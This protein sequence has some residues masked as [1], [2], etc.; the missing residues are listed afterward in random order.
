M[1]K[2]VSVIK[3]ERDD[4]VPIAKEG[5]LYTKLFPHIKPLD[6]ILFKGQDLVSDTIR[7][8]EYVDLKNNW[9]DDYTH[10]GII[11][12]RELLDDERL[13]PSKL[14]VWESTISGKLGGGVYNIQGESHLGVQVRDF[15]EV[16]KAYDEPN[17]TQIAWC[18]LNNNP[19][20]DPEKS[21]EIKTKFRE[22]FDKYNGIRYDLNFFSLF[23]SF[24]N[25]IRPFR[26]FVEIVCRTNKWLFC[27][28]HVA[29]TYKELGLLPEETEER[30]VLPVDFITGVDEDKAIPKHFV[31]YPVRL[32][33]PIHHDPDNHLDVSE[34][35]G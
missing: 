19:W 25:R 20:N 34:L 26:K 17:N 4:Q 15:E 8:I 33:T 18:R 22:I 35:I 3:G 14:Y 32:V 30:D 9:S 23:S 10:C 27:S 1:G 7:L 11:I 21:A 6:L 31:K 12:N 24:Y 16:V 13:D 28:E 29:L 5:Y 2:V